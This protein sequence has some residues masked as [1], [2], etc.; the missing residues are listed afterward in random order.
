LNRAA[1]KVESRIRLGERRDAA[2]APQTVA[3]ALLKDHFEYAG[4][5]Q[6]PN[7]EDDQNGP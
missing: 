4:H 6:Q 7:E 3:P 5:H 2:K 1:L